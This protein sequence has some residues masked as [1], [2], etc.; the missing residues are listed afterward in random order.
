S[1][2]VQWEPATASAGAVGAATVEPPQNRAGLLTS[3]VALARRNQSHLSRLKPILAVESLSPRNRPRT[4]K[5]LAPLRPFPVSIRASKQARA[6]ALTSRERTQ[7]YSAEPE[8][9]WSKFVPG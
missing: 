6:F 9:C 7:E 4:S 3:L 8:P 2:R 1:M 5:S